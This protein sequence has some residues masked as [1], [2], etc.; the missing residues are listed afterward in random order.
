MIHAEQVRQTKLLLQHIADKTTAMADGVYANPVSDYI[1]TDQAADERR[2]LFGNYPLALTLSCRLPNPGDYLSDD[3]SGIPILLVRDRD[4]QVNAFLNVCRH[5]GAQVASGCGNTR[6][7]FTC[8]YH[9][10]NYGLD[11]RLLSRPAEDAFADMDKAAHG[12]VRL[13]VEEKYGMIWVSPAADGGVDLNQVLGGAAPHLEAYGLAG[14]HHYESR[15]MRRQMNWKLVIDTFLE[16]YHVRVLHAQ[17]LNGIV[18]GDLTTFEA[19]GP[20]LQQVVARPS[21]TEITA[22]PEEQWQ[23]TPHAATIYVLF[24]NVV[25]LMQG[26]HLETWHV[27]PDG[28]DVNASQMLISL[29]TPEPATTDSVRGHWDRNFDLLMDVVD[30]EDFPLGERV[31]LGFHSRAQDCITFGRN[32]PSLHHFHRSIRQALGYAPVSDGA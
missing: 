27:Y 8:P 2:L 17:T 29:Y 5:R 7:A 25:F 1:S 3:F 16:T 15:V 4:G 24:P 10:W 11:G 19:L 28:D 31:Q 20:N 32:E 14:Y 23:L 6:R 12:L 9:A 26:D 13:P 30:K 21:I 22:L 18:L